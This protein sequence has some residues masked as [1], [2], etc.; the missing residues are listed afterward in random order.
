MADLSTMRLAVVRQLRR[1]DTVASTQ[2]ILDSGAVPRL[3]G[4]VV[5]PGKV[6]DS[7]YGGKFNFTDA[8]G[9]VQEGEN[10]PL[11]DRNG[12]PLRLMVRSERI[13]THDQAR[14]DIPFKDQIL[15][16]NHH[17][18]RRLVEGVLGTSQHEVPGL[19]NTSVV[20]AAENLIPTL[21]I[22]T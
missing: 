4:Y 5:Q 12:V 21:C 14:G 19:S 20:I 8:S 22:Y 2:E 18:M 6:S 13:S 15:A 7:I 3:D 16:L 10:P 1:G 9:T 17:Y 11:L